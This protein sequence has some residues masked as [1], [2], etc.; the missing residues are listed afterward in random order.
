M[1][2]NINKSQT[3]NLLSVNYNAN[4]RYENSSFRNENVNPI[5]PHLFLNYK[6]DKNNDTQIFC[7]YIKYHF[8]FNSKLNNISNISLKLFYNYL[9]LPF[10]I[11]EKIYNGFLKLYS[12][13]N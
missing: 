7:H 3:N 13:K 2:E 6:Q 5:I 4:E 1:I 10:F 11:S 9:N 8:N 12:S